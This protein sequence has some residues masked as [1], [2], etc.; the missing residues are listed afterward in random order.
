MT[1]P[2]PGLAI[3]A[4]AVTL[5]GCSRSGAPPVFRVNFE[6]TKGPFTVEV[7]REWSPLGAD[8]FYDLVKQGFFTDNRFFRVLPGFIVQF[9]INGDPGLSKKW[10]SATIDDDLVKQ[11]NQRGYLSFA[12]GGPLTRTTQLFINLADNKRL[13]KVGFSPFGK[14]V[15]GMEVVDS[16][17]SGYGEGAPRGPG[18]D[19]ARI[20]AEGNAYL[21]KDFPQLDF[22]KTAKIG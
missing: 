6:T 18:P 14:V 11:T 7:T 13:D 22:I 9:G 8:R 17:Y 3:C 20:E 10:K 19:Q 12:T 16:L 15:S 2:V 1:R 21:Q 4:L 5:I